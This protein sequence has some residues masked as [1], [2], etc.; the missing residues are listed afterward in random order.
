MRLAAWQLYVRF[1][2]VGQ[3]GFDVF[4]DIACAGPCLEA[5]KH[6]VKL[7]G[8]IEHIDGHPYPL[9]SV[10]LPGCHQHIGLFAGHF[11]SLFTVGA[12]G[13]VS[14]GKQPLAGTL[15]GLGLIGF[16]DEIHKPFRAAVNVAGADQ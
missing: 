12:F 9:I 14:L 13:A 1:V 6:S 8:L 5:V 2:W 10:Y 3:V 7:L 16:V 11:D 4:V 15:A